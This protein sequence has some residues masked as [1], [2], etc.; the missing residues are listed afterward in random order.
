MITPWCW[1]LEGLMISFWKIRFWIRFF[2]IYRKYIVWPTYIF[3]PYDFLC[4]WIG[5]NSTFEVH[6]IA[7]F[8]L[9]RI[10]I[11][12]KWYVNFRFIWNKTKSTY[13][14]VKISSD[15][16]LGTT[17]CSIFQKLCWSSYCVNECVINYLIIYNIQCTIILLV[18]STWSYNIIRFWALQRNCNPL[19]ADSA[20]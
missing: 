15:C 3:S 6:I 7:F 19:W 16:K 20:M 9:S 12:T 11:S 10:N 8:D 13:Y 18:S 17:P 14:K 1:C 2:S 5:W 4:L